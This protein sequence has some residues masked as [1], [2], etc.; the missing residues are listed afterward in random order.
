MS[1]HAVVFGA[2]GKTGK[3]LVQQLVASGTKVTAVARGSAWVTDELKGNPLFSLFE[4]QVSEM[5]QEQFAVLLADKSDIYSTLGHNLS[6]K[7]VWGEPRRLVSDT[8]DN[9]CNAIAYLKPN[10]TKKVVLM[11]STGCE[12]KLEKELPPLSQRVAVSVIRALV[13]P[14]ADNESAVASLSSLSANPYIEWSIVRPDALIDEPNVSDYQ[15]VV[16][17]TRNA[18]FSPGQTSRVNVA[19]VMLKLTQ[20]PELWAKWQGKMPVVYNQ[21]V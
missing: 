12:N 10:K 16:S 21:T 7:G 20:Q 13:P 4:T 9:I 19:N 6:F 1:K 14:H 17:P 11:A 5:S 3:L 15:M 8:I 2:S 18:I